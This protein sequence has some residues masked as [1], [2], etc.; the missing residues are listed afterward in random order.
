MTA[1][2]ELEEARRRK[3]ERLYV[4]ALLEGLHDVGNADYVAATQAHSIAYDYNRKRW[5]VY[6]TPIWC[7]DESGEAERIVERTLKSLIADNADHPK[8]SAIARHVLKSL[9]QSRFKAALEMAQHKLPAPREK[10]DADPMLLAVRNGVVDLRTGEHRSVRPSDWHTKVAGANYDCRATAPRWL[11]FLDRIFAGDAEVIGYV[12]R[13]V[14]YNLTASTSEQAWFLLH[15]SGSNGK[16]T[17]LHTIAE[18]LGT[19]ALTAD[20]ET[21]MLKRA[22]KSN[23]DDLARMDGARVILASEGREGRGLD[24]ALIKQLTGGERIVASYKYGHPFE[25]EMRAKIWIATNHRPTIDDDS[26]GTWRRVQLIPFNERIASDECDPDLAE[27]LTVELAGILNWAI[28]GAIEWTHGGLKPPAAIS[29]ATR[30]Y[31]DAEDALAAFLEERCN[32]GADFSELTSDLWKAYL[33]Y[34]SRNGEKPKI[35]S[36]RALGEKLDARGIDAYH[37]MKGNRRI[38]IRLQFDDGMTV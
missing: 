19:Y 28:A 38:G 2:N 32:L 37:S 8:F 10:F 17:L 24:T 23:R 14:G 13:V 20:T 1:A 5:L 12:R 11:Q 7:T 26:F 35:R 31:R 34:A 15:G 21:F 6:K 33:A 3:V 18:L 4:D 29:A 9:N 16:S 30:S 36:Q 27:K 22:E 25:F